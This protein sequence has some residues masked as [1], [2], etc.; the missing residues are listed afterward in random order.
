MRAYGRGRLRYCCPGHTPNTPRNTRAWRKRARQDGAREARVPP[1]PPEPLMPRLTCPDCHGPLDVG[2]TVC[3]DCD[4]RCPAC[5]EWRQ[6]AALCAVCPPPVPPP[7]YAS[8]R[9]P[10]HWLVGCENWTHHVAAPTAHDA[11]ARAARSPGAPPALRA[12]VVAT[13]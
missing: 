4:S 7:W 10:H 3:P 5:G 6:G 9:G 2:G 11:L 13:E 1:T 8:R 12:W